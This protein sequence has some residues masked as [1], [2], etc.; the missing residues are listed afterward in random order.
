M[1]DSTKHKKN[2]KI[3]A[4]VKKRVKEGVPRI[5]IFGE[6]KSKYMDCPSS[7]NTFWKYYK[8]DMDAATAEIIGLVGSKVF[9]RALEE[10]DY[11]HYPSQE[12]ILR[13]KGGWSPTSTSIEVEQ[14]TADEDLTAI[15]VL[16]ELLGVADDDDEEPDSDHPTKEEDNQR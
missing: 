12:L 15:S 14:E 11:G 1:P 4:H 16:E 8:E 10:G 13:S 7:P 6:V 9:E 2:S 5:A 3:S